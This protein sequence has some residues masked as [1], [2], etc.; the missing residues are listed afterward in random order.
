MLH[1]VS[2]Y[3]HL[4]WQQRQ[5]Q[6]TFPDE[7]HISLKLNGYIFLQQIKF[8][9]CM[10]SSIKNLTLQIKK[11]TWVEH[12]LAN[13]K[14]F[15]WVSFIHR[16]FCTLHF[17]YSNPSTLHHLWASKDKWEMRQPTRNWKN[18]LLQQ[19]LL[20]SNI[21]WY[22]ES[23]NTKVEPNYYN[24]ETF[25]QTI[26]AFPSTAFQFLIYAHKPW[27]KLNLQCE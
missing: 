22:E 13:I 23:A 18:N 6:R 25:F 9:V 12:D 1:S 4:E 14:T 19:N 2:Q 15:V 26:I 24:L 21:L 7:N 20:D 5:Q 10:R 3:S 8:K 17:L 11:L 27:S 16:W